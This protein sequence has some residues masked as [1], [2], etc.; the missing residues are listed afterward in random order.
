MTDRER[1]EAILDTL[2]SE[3]WKCINSDIKEFYDSINQI[4]DVNSAEELA[5]RKGEL[6]RL[7]FILNLED[8]YQHQLDML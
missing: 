2:T 7:G 4:D 8:W 5:F 6:A 3:G 1:L